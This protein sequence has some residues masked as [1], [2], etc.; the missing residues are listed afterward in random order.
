MDSDIENAYSLLFSS[1][2]VFTVTLSPTLELES[3]HSYTVQTVSP[4]TTVAS[5]GQAIGKIVTSGLS[6]DNVYWNVGN[7]N[8]AP[9]EGTRRYTPRKF[10]A[11]DGVVYAWKWAKGE[12]WNV[13]LS[14]FKPL[15][16]L[17]EF[18]QSNCRCAAGN[19]MSLLPPYDLIMYSVKSNIHC[20]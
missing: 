4:T 19:L 3:K 13:S 17:L 1:D 8:I 14:Y 16:S 12:G 11:S 6:L 15:L 5:N 20:C 7:K 18:I 10:E 9:T 2:N